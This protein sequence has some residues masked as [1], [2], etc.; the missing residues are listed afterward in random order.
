MAE[1]K[2]KKIIEVLYSNYKEK[3][4]FI[5][6]KIIERALKNQQN[7]SIHLNDNNNLG[8]LDNNILVLQE[9]NENEQQGINN[10]PGDKNS[11]ELV[12]ANTNH[13]RRSLSGEYSNSELSLNKNE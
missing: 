9:S 13:D 5:D 8:N 4:Y 2:A 11:T 12:R 10:S 6:M 1:K 3:V 7:N